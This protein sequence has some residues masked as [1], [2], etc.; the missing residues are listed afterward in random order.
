[1]SMGD[2]ERGDLA[3]EV[4]GERLVVGELDRAL[5]GF[6]IS[7]APCEKC[8]MA[9]SPGPKL[10]CALYAAKPNSIPCSQNTGTPHLIAS[11][12]TGATLFKIRYISRK[13]DLASGGAASMY[14]S[15][16]A[17]PFFA[18]FISSLEIYVGCAST[19]KV[20]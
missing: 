4:F 19:Y 3:N 10:T 15:I 12:P 17:G 20:Y 13:C 1:M 5:P 2:A 14:S 7:Q 8:S 16:V 11:V 18:M 6:E 9:A